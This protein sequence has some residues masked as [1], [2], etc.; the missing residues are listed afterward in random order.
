MFLAIRHPLER[1][2]RL[3]TVK[4]EITMMQ[5]GFRAHDLGTFS[6]VKELAKKA[7]SYK[8]PVVIHLAMKKT[9]TSALPPSR[10]TA[11][12]VRS[13]HAAVVGKSGDLFS[14]SDDKEPK[15]TAGRPALE[16]LKGSFI[17][18]ICVLVVR[19]FGG[20]LLGT[21]GLVQAY[22]DSVKGVLALCE[23]EEMV[24]KSSFRIVL[25]YNLYEPVKKE[26]LD[27]GSVIETEA[28]TTEVV[29]NGSVASSACPLL[30]QRIRNLTK[31]QALVSFTAIS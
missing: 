14:F 9:I 6:S 23:T 24:E 27:A 29:I 15:N 22:G 25:P 13:I 2:L 16:I 28:F 18:D 12:Y 5:I 11:E 17:T 1:H 26:L 20:T 7:A 21:G 30:E 4:E 10:Y 8:K 3:I 19:Y 31:A